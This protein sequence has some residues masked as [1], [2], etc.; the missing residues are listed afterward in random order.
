MGFAIVIAV[1]AGG[2]MKVKYSR[3]YLITAQLFFGLGLIFSYWLFFTSVYVIQV[4][5]PWCLVVTLSTTIIFEALLRYNL[6]YNVFAFSKATNKKVQ[7]F[8]ANGYDIL[9]VASW[10]VLM[11]VLVVLKFGSGLFS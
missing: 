5:C 7:S 10:V 11:T 1:A 6:K 3:S 9:I 2:L 8:I 4:L